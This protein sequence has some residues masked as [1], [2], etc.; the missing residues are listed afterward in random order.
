MNVEPIPVNEA[1]ARL[2]PFEVEANHLRETYPVWY[3]AGLTAI[4]IVAGF[5]LATVAVMVFHS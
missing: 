3:G 5:V 4:L 2:T 1:E